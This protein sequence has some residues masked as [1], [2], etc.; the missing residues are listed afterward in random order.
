MKTCRETK[1]IVEV[2]K[3]EEAQKSTKAADKGED[4]KFSNTSWYG[5]FRH[6]VVIQLRNVETGRLLNPYGND[7]IMWHTED[8]KGGTKW[9]LEYTGDGQ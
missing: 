8:G 1:E 7:V 5:A 2:L 6:G 4:V 9:M 3:R